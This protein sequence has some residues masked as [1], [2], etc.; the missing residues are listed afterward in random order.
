MAMS[1]ASRRVGRK[2]ERRADEVGGRMVPPGMPAVRGT[3]LSVSLFGL[4]RV[5]M[6]VGEMG[7][8]L[9]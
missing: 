8:V 2:G 7:D 5:A 6:V 4:R 3:P 9:G 1:C